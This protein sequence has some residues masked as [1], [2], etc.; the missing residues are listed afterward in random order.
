MHLYTAH[1]DKIKLKTWTL[2]LIH[3]TQIQIIISN[4]VF[5]KLEIVPAKAVNQQS[6]LKKWR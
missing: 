2:Q 3:Q 6:V 5:V 4:P 1:N